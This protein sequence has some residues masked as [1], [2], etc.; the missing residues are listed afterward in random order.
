VGRGGGGGEVYEAKT[1]KEVCGTFKL[2]L[3][4]PERWGGVRIIPSLGEVLIFSGTT[5]SAKT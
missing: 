3:E 5:H 1:F 2:K 4:F